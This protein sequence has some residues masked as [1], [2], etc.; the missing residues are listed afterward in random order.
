MKN[1]KPFQIV[2]ALLLF[3]I[4]IIGALCLG[5][6]SD[7]KK[8]FREMGAKIESIQLRLYGAEKDINVLQS[9]PTLNK[10]YV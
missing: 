3:C 5:T 8:E 7:L 9:K 2:V 10:A 6:I 4:N 1:D